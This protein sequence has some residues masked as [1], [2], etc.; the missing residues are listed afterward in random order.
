MHP[1]EFGG[2]VTLIFI[3]HFIPHGGGGP[4][5]GPIGVVDKRNS[6]LPKDPLATTDNGS[7]CSIWQCDILP[8]TMYIVMM[9]ESAL[10]HATQTAIL[11]TNYLAHKLKITIKCSTEENC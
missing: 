11:S 10:G 1:G 8:I 4:G 2:D 7:F 5:V 3:K 9:G 6:Y